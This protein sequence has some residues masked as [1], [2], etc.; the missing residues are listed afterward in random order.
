VQAGGLYPISDVWYIEPGLDVPDRL[1]VHIAQ[2]A[3]EIAEEADV[4][5][6]RGQRR[7]HR[8]RLRGA[9]AVRALPPFARAVLTLHAL[10]AA[11]RPAPASMARGWP[12]TWR[13]AAWR[14]R[15]PRLSDAALVKLFRLLRLARRLLDLEPARRPAPRRLSRGHH[16]GTASAQPGRHRPGAA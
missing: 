1:R 2:F 5:G 15:Y 6:H 10:S 16:V 7:R 3:R 4:A 14:R 8:L 11:P 12:T 9:P 13:P